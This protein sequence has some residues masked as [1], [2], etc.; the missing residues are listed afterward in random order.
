MATLSTRF[1]QARTEDYAALH[2]QL[3][4][5][6]ERLSTGLKVDER[7]RMRDKLKRPRQ[8]YAYIARIDFFNA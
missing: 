5:L 1:R 7:S 2:A 8:Q 3:T 4:G 6:E